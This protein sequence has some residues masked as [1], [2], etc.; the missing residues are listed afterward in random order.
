ML[1]REENDLICRVGP[2]TPMGKAL[3]RYWTPAMQSSDLPE[4]GGDPFRL[5]LLGQGFVAFRGEDGQVA[6][7]DEACCHRGVSLALGHVEGCGIRCIFHGWKF[8]AD[9][10]LV[11]APNVSEPG[12]MKRVRQRSYPVREA[13]GVIWVYLGPKELEPPFQHHAWF[14]LPQENRI[15]AYLVQEAN[16]VQTM[17]GLFDSSHLNI[18]HI[19]SLKAY[20]KAEAEFMQAAPSVMSDTAPYFEAED[21]D[22]GFHYAALR[23]VG[24]GQDVRIAPFIAPYASINPNGDLW[25]AVTPIDDTHCIYFH[26]WWDASKPIG[27]DPYRAHHLKFVGLDDETLSNFGQTYATI[28]NPDR[29]QIKNGFK[30]DRA[31]MREGRSWSGFPAFTQ[32]DSAVQ[33]SA[34]AL[35]DRTIENLCNADLGIIKLYQNLRRIALDVAAGKEPLGLHADPTQIFGVTAVVP[36]EGWQA[37]VPTHKKRAKG[38]AAPV[39]YEAALAEA[40]A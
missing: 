30:Q 9:G 32:D 36:P 15:N 21:T 11:D 20:Q 22:F 5:V 16:Y 34:G 1:S 4:A 18:L 29:P 2:E 37:L 14:D 23:N 13:G 19:D 12:F 39:D 8:A 7:L 10:E 25:M 35:R 17:E 3:R 6:I 24:D 38:G 26:V 27:T 33:M 28:N 40:D 31:A